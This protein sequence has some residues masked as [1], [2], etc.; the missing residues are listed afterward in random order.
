MPKNPK[1]KIWPN[2]HL[3]GEMLCQ[4]H[5]FQDKF[6]TIKFCELKAE[7]RSIEDREIFYKTTNLNTIFSPQMLWQILLSF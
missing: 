3:Y 2:R 4:L 5:S 1:H 7:I 6:D